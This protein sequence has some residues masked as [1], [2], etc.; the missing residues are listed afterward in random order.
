MKIL[1][2]Y[3]DD[4]ARVLFPQAESIL[5]NTH[6]RQPLPNLDDYNLVIFAGGTD[7]S[8]MFYGENAVYT[9]SD[10]P[11]T[12][13]IMEQAIFQRAWR[14]E[15]PM[16]GICR[17]AQLL[18]VLNGGRLAQHI[19]GHPYKH[20]FEI[21]GKIIIGNTTHHQALLEDVNFNGPDEIIQGEKISK[22]H[23][24]FGV[25]PN[26]ANIEICYWNGTKSL[27]IQ[28]HPEYEPKNSPWHQYCVKLIED[29]LL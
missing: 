8:T 12:R 9:E 19:E 4:I 22:A 11:S 17:G 24:E 16:L 21:D 5:F 1:S 3:E 10:W 29:Y 13:D 27:C 23:S 6:K 26:Q 2:L 14:N 25:L 15:V 7:I 20:P 28:G 18:H